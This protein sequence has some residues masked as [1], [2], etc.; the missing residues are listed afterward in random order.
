MYS[1]GRTVGRISVSRAAL[2]LTILAAC[3]GM[4]SSTASAAVAPEAYLKASNTGSSDFF[5]AVAISGDTMVVGAPGEDSS[6]IGVNGNQADNSA[7]N[8]GAAYV[9]VRTGS[10]WTQQAYLK[11]SNTGAEDQFGQSV[12][13]SGN[14]IVVGAYLEDSNASGIDGNQADNSAANSGAAYVFG[15]N[16]STWSQLAY[17]KASNSGEDQFGRS[18]SISGETVVVGARLEDSNATG[19]NGNQADNSA[20]NSGAAYVFTR[21]GS[22]WSQPAYLKASNTA[23]DDQ[24]G[25]SVA[26]SGDTIVV[27]ALLEDSNA[28]G[29]NGN[30]AD[31]S[32]LE[33]GAAYVFTRIGSTWSQQA[34]LKASN[35]GPSEYFGTMVAISGDTIVVGVPAENSNATGVNGNQ[36]DNSASDSGAAYVFARTGSTWGQQAY[37]KA[38]NTGVSDQFGGSAAI[39]GDTIVIGAIN[40]DSN[41][42]VING[43]GS[44]NSASDAGAAYMFTRSGSTWSPGAYLKATNTE[45]NDQF[46]ATVAI[47]DD[48]V[49]V[50]A[51]QDDSSA[52]G[53]GGNQASNSVIDSGAAFTYVIDSDNDGPRDGRDNCPADANPSQVDLDGD[54]IGDVCDP[55]DDNDGATDGA[56][57]CPAVANP[58]QAD[59]DGDKTGDVC[60]PDDDNDGAADGA[61]NCPAVANPTQADADGDGV[62]AACDPDD[63]NGGG[64]T[65][66]GCVVPKLEKGTSKRAVKG[67][68]TEAG[69]A[70]G[71]VKKKPSSK[72]DKRK[73]IKLKVK[74]GT[75][76]PAGA[77]I[78]A[79]FSSGPR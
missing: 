2:A 66:P 64:G 49:V 36:A 6:A 58:T 55:D 11:A 71:R 15:R 14:T 44:D 73:L 65:E 78:P 33:S 29:V 43:N 18:V 31:N 67:S 75:E 9:Y 35:T 63:G 40:E 70:L 21:S 54:N 28:T 77:S 48:T 46:A 76:L 17:L 16:G 51:S 79:V 38:P 20:A 39:S 4:T 42:T 53:V 3:L 72:V 52:T 60:D 5:G 23:A 25:Q 8:S 45:A 27:G 32:I 74:P 61:D 37:L 7:S 19:I 47:S 56:D 34:Y 62:G 26:I 24:F 41:A 30:Q 1:Q 22:T 68:L 69:C 12:A 13:I 50:G 59:A 10:T 57:N